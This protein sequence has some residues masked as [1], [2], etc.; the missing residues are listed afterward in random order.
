MKNITICLLATIALFSCNKS[1]TPPPQPPAG[2]SLLKS[3]TVYQPLIHVRTLIV[4]GYDQRTLLASAYVHNFDSS[5]AN[6]VVDS[7]LLSFTQPD[8]TT[9]PGSYDLAFYNTAGLPTGASEHHLLTYDNLS[10]VTGDSVSVNQTNNYTTSHYTYDGMGNTTIETFSFDPQTP[11]SLTYQQVDTM[12]LPQDN[13]LTDIGYYSPGGELVHIVSRTFSTNLNP[14]YNP[15]LTNNLSTIFTYNNLIDFKSENLPD[16]YTYQ[17]ANF[18][19]THLNFVWT[20]D[21]V[22]RVV[23]GIGSDPNSGTTGQIYTYSY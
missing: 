1:N 12:F 2:D 4:L 10:R 22:G 15:H 3:I 19:I 21:A 20:K 16:Q 11:G 23:Q 5:G 6:I 9:P 18:N 8:S 13:L 17:D 7:T 14:L